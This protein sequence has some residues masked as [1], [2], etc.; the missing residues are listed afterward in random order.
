[1][2]KSLVEDCIKALK[3]KDLRETAANALA[4]VGPDAKD[5]IPT[6]LEILLNERSNHSEHNE[7]VR[8]LAAMGKQAVPALAKVA[9][10][11]DSAAR[12]AAMFA[13]SQLDGEEKVAVPILINALNDDRLIATIALGKLG[14]KACRAAIALFVFYLMDFLGTDEELLA[15]ERWALR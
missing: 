6:L 5:A 12:Y 10:D 15:L 8:A 3:E 7:S 11:Q 14:G 4:E 1:K 2:E 9:L 13:L